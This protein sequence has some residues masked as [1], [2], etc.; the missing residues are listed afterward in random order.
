MQ[1]NLIG[2]R[3]RQARLNKKIS[4]DELQRTT[5]IQKR[6]LEALE[7]NAFEVIPGTFYV[8]AFIRQYAEAVGENG[9]QLVA[10]FDGKEVPE[11][12]VIPPRPKPEPIQASRKKA[13]VEERSKDI[14]SYLPMIS[15]GLVALAIIF[16]VAYMMMENRQSQQ[17][18]TRPS[19]SVV[20]ERSSSSSEPVASTTT[21]PSTTETST[22]ETSEAPPMSITYD[23]EDGRA[24]SMTANEVASPATLTFVGTGSCW[25]GVQVNGGYIYQYTLSAGVTQSTEIPAGTGAVTIV[26]GAAPNVT[27]SLN[28]EALNFNP[29]NNNVQR[30]DINL[31][32]NYQQ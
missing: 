15:L 25:V 12:P 20:I 13:H 2:K 30:K 26:L 21:E 10:I 27:M 5:K 24:V 6:Y 14:W 29:N 4:I 11:E 22:T 31:T 1:Q 9:D 18:I 19:D 17:M 8:R 32:L 16:V 3:L 23:G 28:D 7:A